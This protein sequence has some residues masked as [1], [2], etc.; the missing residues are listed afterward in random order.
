MVAYVENEHIKIG[1]KTAGSEL[2]S[3][4]SKDSGIEYLWQGNPDVWYGQ[5]PVLFPIIGNVLDGKYFLDG[6]WAED[7]TLTGAKG[8]V[9]NSFAAV[10]D[11]VW[12]T[13]AM[14]VSPKAL[15]TALGKAAPAFQGTRQQDVH[16]LLTI[17]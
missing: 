3:F 17:L 7:V 13:T 15:F 1:V 14:S 11:E 8:E 6:K 10:L 9:A 16:E 12:T 4:I 2:T 5:S